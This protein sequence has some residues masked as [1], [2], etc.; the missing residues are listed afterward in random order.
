MPFAAEELVGPPRRQQIKAIYDSTD[1]EVSAGRM[2][3]IAARRRISTSST[4]HDAVPRR[5]GAL[6]TRR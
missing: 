6:G 5:R 1:N 3:V 4:V 2:S